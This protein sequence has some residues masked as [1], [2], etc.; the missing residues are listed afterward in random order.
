MTQPS[1]T[2]VLALPA[3]SEQYG[4]FLTPNDSVH[5]YPQV[6]MVNLADF[7]GREM[8]H[9]DIITYSMKKSDN[10]PQDAIAV[11]LRNKFPVSWWKAIKL[12]DKRTNTERVTFH[13]LEKEKKMMACHLALLRELSF[14]TALRKKVEPKRLH[15]GAILE[16]SATWEGGA[17]FP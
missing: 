15:P 16:N 12:H 7:N 8:R 4:L 2:Q 1:T 3:R 17:V 14:F 9:G 10:I 5:S 13:F 6:T 11:E